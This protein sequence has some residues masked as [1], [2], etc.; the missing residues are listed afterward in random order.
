LTVQKKFAAAEAEFREALRL[1][2][3]YP[4]AHFNLGAVLAAQNQLP[5]AIAE[6]REA[7]RLR[8]DYPE[9]HF[10]LGNAL[11]RQGKLPDAVAEYREVL[12]LRPDDAKAHLSLGAAWAE[13]G[14][15]SEA[16]AEFREAIR[17]WPDYAEAHYDLGLALRSLGDFSGSLVA[18]R[19][20]DE[21]GQKQP[22]WRYPSADW[23]RQAE[24][25]VE[26][27]ARLP[28]LLR[29][30]RQPRDAVEQLELAQACSLKK[31][32]AVPARFWAD[33]FAA[34]PKRADDLGRQHRY[35]A[36]CAAALAG[37][38][39]S[40]DA[41]GLPDKVR[42]GLRR[43]ARAWLADDVKALAVLLERNQAAVTAEVVRRLQ[44]WKQDPDLAAVRDPDAL[45]ALPPPERDAWRQLW[46][47][48]DALLQR[49]AQ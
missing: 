31:Q 2:P 40:E 47:D 17:L 15:L 11:N 27:E 46:Q 6:Y 20:G 5:E 30:D 1:R 4:K 34:D 32:R 10:N 3:D 24:R 41:A 14:K 16:V 39:K 28:A 45:D 43:Q 42:Q 26:L 22:G 7:L 49:A 8:P 36:A 38:G 12:R 33:A 13:Q 44:H 19:R 35:N 21:L 25:L 37:C 9:A 18:L 29:G 23:V 48:V